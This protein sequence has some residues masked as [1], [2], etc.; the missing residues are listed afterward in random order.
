MKWKLTLILLS[1]IT[2]TW[3]QNWSSDF[4]QTLAL[5]QEEQKPVLLYFS[6]SD[7]CIP[8]IELKQ[9]I[10]NTDQFRSF[11]QEKLL[12]VQADF[13]RKRKNALPPD[14]QKQNEQLAEQYNP[15]G[16]FPLLVLLNKEGN[17][18]QQLVF[19]HQSVEVFIQQFP[20]HSFSQKE[21]KKQGYLREFGLMGSPTQIKIVSD[22][23]EEAS[24][25]LIIDSTIQ[26]MKRIEQLI[27][28][29][30]SGS[31]TSEINRQAGITATRVNEELFDLIKR[32]KQISVLTQGAFDI[33]FASMDKIWF[34]DGSMKV[35][36]DSNIVAAAKA[37]IDY[38]KIE[39]KSETLEVFLQ[40]KGMKIGFGAIGKGYV[41]ERAKAFLQ[42][43]GI[44]NG[45][46]NAGGDLT[47]WGKNEMG[48]NWQVGIARPDGAEGILAKLPIQNQ[49]IVTSGNYEKYALIDGIRYAHI[50]DPRTG[51]PATGIKSV[52]VVAPSAELADA[53]ATA[54]FVMGKEAGLHLVNQMKDIECLIIDEANQLFTSDLLDLSYE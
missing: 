20:T 38:Q 14:I 11:A 30:K 21:I 43:R 5:A 45:L 7:W 40:E 28:S 50:I 29:W 3:S 36:P 49:A 27:S 9:S 8:C 10:F 2:F 23:L 6:G 46:V 15:Q 19:E 13:P 51:Y 53:L 42:A 31:Q 47:A 34:F 37:H 25:N 24:A 33:S 22:E 35:L 44:K 16:Y 32:A 54:V 48:E 1:T 12:L 4:K 41:A 26:E 17:L 39:L 52:T 18:I